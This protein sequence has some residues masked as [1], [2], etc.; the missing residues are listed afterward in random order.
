VRGEDG[1]SHSGE[2]SDES[3]AVTMRA[4]VSAS[5]GGFSFAGDSS[6]LRASAFAGEI[7]SADAAD[8]AGGSASARRATF[9]GR[10]APKLLLC[11]PEAL[12]LR[13][14]LHRGDAASAPLAARRSAAPD[15][16]DDSDPT[17]GVARWAGADF[18]ARSSDSLVNSDSDRALRPATSG[19]NACDLSTEAGWEGLFLSENS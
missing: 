6:S 15:S 17:A 1:L 2:S 7:A 18:L 9:A 12:Q 4:G 5:T 19:Q 14:A 3:A 8:A 10:A 11:L 16:D 13:A